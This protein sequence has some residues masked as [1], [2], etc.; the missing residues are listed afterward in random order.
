MTIHVTRPGHLDVPLSTRARLQPWYQPNFISKNLQ[1]DTNVG[2][3]GWTTRWSYTVPSGRLARVYSAFLMVMR[4]TAPTTQ[5][6]VT[7]RIAKSPLTLQVLRV[8]QITSSVGTPVL[9]VLGESSILM[10]GDT[11]D[12]RTVDISTGGT[13]FLVESANIGEFDK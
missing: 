11:L 13:N 9:G 2:P 8:S 1:H 6:E 10:A 12:A 7:S 4:S 5:G 3:H